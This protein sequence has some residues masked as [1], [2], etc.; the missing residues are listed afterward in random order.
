[1]QC[2][3]KKAIP[4]QTVLEHVVCFG[5]LG[6]EGTAARA[7]SALFSRRSFLILSASAIASASA[8]LITYAA[9][10]TAS[11]DAPAFAR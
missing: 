3:W 2:P 5:V 10:D 9:F 6:D 7:M 8:G 1:P 11:E 4:T